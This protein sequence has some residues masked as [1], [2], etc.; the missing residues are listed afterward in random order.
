MDQVRSGARLLWGSAAIVVVAAAAIASTD[1]PAF[2]S[3]G[4][5]GLLLL[6]AVAAALTG[7]EAI[8]MALAGMLLAV[9]L[10]TIFFP[11]IAGIPAFLAFLGAAIRLH[12][13]LRLVRA[14]ASPRPNT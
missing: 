4:V 5:F 7:H 11:F 10:A 9:P 1:P 3:Y 6:V 14:A 2:P 13:R 12:G 8:G